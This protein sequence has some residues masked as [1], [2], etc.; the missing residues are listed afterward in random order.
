M[1]VPSENVCSPVSVYLSELGKDFILQ[2]QNIVLGL[3]EGGLTPLSTSDHN[4]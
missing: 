1:E 3:V 2:V 4:L